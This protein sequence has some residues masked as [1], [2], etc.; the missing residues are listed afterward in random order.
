MAALTWGW[1]TLWRS[2]F[3]QASWS[4]ERM[5]GV[6][7]G[8]ALEPALR[9]EAGPDPEVLQP[10]LG[11]AAQF[12][13][14]NP[15]LAPA[16]I[17]AIAR[18]EADRT[19]GAQV[20]RLRTALGGPLGAL[21]DRL[22]WAGLQPASVS[23][24]LLAVALGAGLPAVGVAVL[25]YNG[26]RWVLGRWLLQVGWRHGTGVGAA[27][28]SSWLP[29]AGAVAA[30]VAAVLAALA[31]PP[32][33]VALLDTMPPQALV[34]ASATA[35][36]MLAARRFRRRATPPALT[37]AGAVFVVLWTWGVA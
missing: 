32:V 22:F 15:Y 30:T 7:L 4:Y 19:P 25:A 36:A 31:I 23:A 1:R 29:R 28:G 21:G 24:V 34:A 6:G 8:H 13:N 14:A 37:L 10:A 5:Q 3:I 20:Q 35:V 27:L 9:A 26:F 12:F 16:A 11:R 2:L 17:G 18:A 33:I